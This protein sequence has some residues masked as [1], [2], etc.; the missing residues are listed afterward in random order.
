MA[1]ASLPPG[2]FMAG[3]VGLYALYARQPV[4]TG[5]SVLPAIM[6]HGTINAGCSAIPVNRQGGDPR[7]DA[8][9]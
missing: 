4:T 7:P 5:I 9:V 8:I 3:A 6:L 1:Q 2:R